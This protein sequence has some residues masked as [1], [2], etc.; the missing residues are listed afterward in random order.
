MSRDEWCMKE[1]YRYAADKCFRTGANT[2]H[3]INR[4]LSISELKE[5]VNEYKQPLFRQHIFWRWNVTRV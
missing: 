3:N 4:M 2:Q 5:C 1:W